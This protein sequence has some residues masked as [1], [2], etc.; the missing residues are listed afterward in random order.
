MQV[1][2]D[3]NFL[4]NYVQLSIENG[5][6]PY[7]PESERS[8]M[9]NIDS[10]KNQDRQESPAHALRFE[11]YELPKPVPVKAPS[12][13]A[14]ITDLVPVSESIY[15]KEASTA[16]VMPFTSDLLSNDAGVKLRL[17]GVQKKWGKPAYS[18]SSGSSA[19]T[20]NTQKTT[21]GI[22]GIDAADH[23]T[24]IPRDLSYDSTSKQSAQVSEEKQKLAA[25]LFGASSSKA[26]RRSVHKNGKGSAAHAEKSSVGTKSVS[27]EGTQQSIPPPDLLDFSEETVSETASSSAP[28]ED[29][30]GQ[31]DGL[32]GPTLIT[33]TSNLTADTVKPPDLMALY[34]DAPILDTTSD[35]AGPS[36]VSPTVTNPNLTD[37]RAS[38]SNSHGEKTETI[39][40]KGPNSQASLEKF[41]IARQVGVTPTGKNPNL[42]SD[43]LG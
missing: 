36:V 34:T 6:R 22:T 28:V 8:G 21:N 23:V 20:S 14:S 9:F 33:S 42:F 7:I 16:S 31:L 5:D 40:K 43:L 41:T 38:N 12:S 39:V 1:D 35:F 13:A 15:S 2:K 27:H 18:S 30:F 24:S 37:L 3:L 29:P 19:S 10:F 26:G 25:S 11:A 32:L 4:N 17:E